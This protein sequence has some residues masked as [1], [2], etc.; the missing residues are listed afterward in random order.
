M[1][2][3]Y[4]VLKV[5][6]VKSKQK[7]NCS[8]IFLAIK[9]GK[10][11]QKEKSSEVNSK[12]LKNETPVIDKENSEDNNAKETHLNSGKKNNSDQNK[13]SDNKKI[14]KLS[15][16]AEDISSASP[17]DDKSE[18]TTSIINT[19]SGA[20]GQTSSSEL[21]ITAS[22]DE[23]ISQS[24]LQA[25]T[26]SGANKKKI[27]KN[28]AGNDYNDQF[29]TPVKQPTSSVGTTVSEN[30]EGDTTIAET[31]ILPTEGEDISINS[32]VTKGNNSRRS[33]MNEDSKAKGSEDSTASKRYF[34]P[35]IQ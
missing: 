8:V 34:T 20:S 24:S 27:I 31:T 19:S 12:K 11:S 33:E 21:N 16:V 7:L 4:S 10:D 1:P 35:H 13:T 5:A 23:Q 17:L 6:H 18:T 26:L 14:L 30:K 25:S 32:N 15:T 2:L 29:S 22:L 3:N 28:T 9:G